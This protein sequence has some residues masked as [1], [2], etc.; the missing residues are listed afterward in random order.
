MSRLPKLFHLEIQ[1]IMIRKLDTL[2]MPFHLDMQ[3]DYIC[4]V[5]LQLLL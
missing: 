4:F 5:Y 1:Y 2:E 3:M